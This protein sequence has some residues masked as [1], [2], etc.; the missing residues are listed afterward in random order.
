MYRYKLNLRERD[1]DRVQ[2]QEERI[3]AFD[4]IEKLLNNLY[5]LLDQAKDETIAHYQEKPSSYE[6]V[7]G[8]D[9]IIE[10][11]KDIETLLT[12]EEE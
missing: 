6:V 1:E 7:I 10:Y 12:R 3:A 9:L 4:Q 5:P 2:F 11:I 8:T